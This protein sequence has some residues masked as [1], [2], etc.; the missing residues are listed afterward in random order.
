[1][2]LLY[3]TRDSSNGDIL[4]LY[5]NSLSS[6]SISEIKDEINK[7]IV[8]PRFRLHWLN[9]DETVKTILPQE[10]IISGSYSENYQNGQRR[11]LSVELYNEDGRYL[12]SINGLWEDVKFSFEIGIELDDG[13]TLWFPKGV[14]YISHISVSHSP[15]KKNV[16]VELSDK[17]SAL[18]GKMGTLGDTYVIPAGNN[19]RDIIN[20]VLSSSKGNG[21][22]LDPKEIIYPSVFESKLTQA[23]IKKESG[24]TY[25]DIII[26]LA[27]QLSAEVFY[28]VDGHL[29]LVP[30]NYVTNDTD[31]PIIFQFYDHFGDL[32]S[33]DMSFDLSDVVNRI[34]VIGSSVSG[35]ISRAIAVNGN[36]DSPLCY[37]RIGYRTASPINDTNITSNIL[38]QERADYELRNKLILKSSVSLEIPFNPLLSV[39]N[40]IG[41]TDEYYGIE[42]ERFL[43]QSISYSIND[44]GTMSISC[45]NIR[46]LPFISK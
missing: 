25:G 44:S 8:R 40:L 33:N 41:I 30:I 14:F 26:D 37:Q 42:Q 19:I 28:D 35:K 5:S 38:A 45:S 3:R 6:I 12:P 43:I 29:T 16:T 39:N 15:S 13:D 23:E 4:I 22:L 27:T 9:P 24:A 20:D 31:K 34:I 32:I 2:S 46:N 10:D 1:M 36:A 18:E 7:Q 11:S 21:E 17:F